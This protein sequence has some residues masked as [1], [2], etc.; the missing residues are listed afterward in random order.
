M[1]SLSSSLG[2]THP[3]WGGIDA[4]RS[5]IESVHRPTVFR[6]SSVYA[7]SLWQ[8]TF[9]T[10]ASLNKRGATYSDPYYCEL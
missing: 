10:A 9:V 5:L 3:D 7:S 2:C 6:H 8:I 1:L 4:A